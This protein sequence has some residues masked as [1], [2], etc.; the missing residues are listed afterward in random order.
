MQP[1]L[2]LLILSKVYATSIWEIL[3]Y[4]S[5]FLI[6]CNLHILLIHSIYQSAQKYNT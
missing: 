6:D 2:I 4:Q 3:S 5:D 1:S